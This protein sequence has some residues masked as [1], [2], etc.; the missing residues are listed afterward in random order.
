MR[1]LRYFPLSLLMLIAGCQ[2]SALNNYWECEHLSDSSR[3]VYDNPHTALKVHL[4]KLKGDVVAIISLNQQAFASSTT[5]VTLMIDEVESKEIC[6]LRPGNMKI[7]LGKQLTEQ[8]INA[9]N[10]QKEIAIMAGGF[11]E[12]LPTMSFENKYIEFSNGRHISSS[13][14]LQSIK[15]PLE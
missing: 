11:K 3:L 15:G 4:S 13:W 8:L 2:S 12:Q 9:L 1:R 5:E 10:N 7:K 6:S 14:L